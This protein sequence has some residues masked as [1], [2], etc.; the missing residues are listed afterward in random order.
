MYEAGC[1]LKRSVA[2]DVWVFIKD[3]LDEATYK[4]SG[5]S[6]SSISEAICDRSLELS[7]FRT[8]RDDF[9]F[10]DAEEDAELVSTL[11]WLC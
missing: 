5:S 11:I 3:P 2:H 1:H 6:A 8:S 7:A 9:L 10:A 4:A